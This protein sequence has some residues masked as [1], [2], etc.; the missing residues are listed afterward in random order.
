M[1]ARAH[2]LEGLKIALD[3]LDEVIDTIRRS[4]TPETA[5]LN[6]QR[7][8]KLTETQA[9]AILELQLRRLASLERRRI[10]QE[11]KEVLKRI[12]YL[13]DLLADKHKILSLVKDDILDLRERFG[14]A[15]RTRICSQ[16]GSSEFHAKDL[17]PDEDVALVLT[18]NG[19]AQR[20]RASALDGSRAARNLIAKTSNEGD[21]P[22]AIL[23]ANSR[24]NLLLL[25]DRGRGFTVPAHQ[26]PDASQE[27]R[28]LSL[29]K[30]IHLAS[31]ERIV[32][33]VHVRQFSEGAYLCFATRMGQAKRLALG[34]ASGL[35]TSGDE[36]IGLADGDSLVWGAVTDGEQ[37]I[38]FITQ[39]GRAIRFEENTVRPQGTSAM[40]MRGISLKENDLV[41][42][43]DLV[44]EG[45]ELLLVTAN[46]FAK[47][48]P[49]EKFSLQGR[50]GIGLLVVNVSKSETTGPITDAQVVLP[51]EELIFVT[52][53][54]QMHA[55]S[56]SDVPS[57]ARA[58]WGRLVT[59]TRRNAVVK[60]KDE[61]VQHFVR[62]PAVAAGGDGRSS[63][64]STR[65]RQKSGKRSKRSSTESSSESSSTKSERSQSSTA[66]KEHSIT[67]RDSQ[68]QSPQFRSSDSSQK[69]ESGQAGAS[70]KD[71]EPKSPS[72]S[73]RRSRRTRR[74][75]VSKPPSRGRSRK[76][77]S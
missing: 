27:T 31:Q 29:R 18:A 1:K 75:T 74:T 70:T 41:A 38:M 43:A 14:D 9:L 16:D 52:S 44:R 40:G 59:R 8:L 67:T 55:I 12:E 57:L 3:N 64:Q 68:K 50:G 58:S 10:E 45:G 71:G 2:V 73:P 49:V 35:G 33:A 60:V 20:V 4:R 5:S 51:S 15:R 72:K 53:D 30:L 24:E 6:L 26:I 42:A 32:A 37:E 28:G 11:Y 69:A 66:R 36:V 76:S 54:H 19:Y 47:R 7:K 56:A 13:E 46:G 21:A 22:W 62:L 48:T 65:K 25:T 17:V 63:G 34:E 23:R 39:W 77:G 61:T